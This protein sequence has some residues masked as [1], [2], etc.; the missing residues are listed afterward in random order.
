MKKVENGKELNNLKFR[1]IIFIIVF[2]FI[3]GA[4]SFGLNAYVKTV[5]DG[6]LEMKD[7]GHGVFTYYSSII[8]YMIIYKDRKVFGPMFNISRYEPFFDKMK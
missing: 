1:S 5:N 4:I 8:C 7:S 2:L 3:C 6:V